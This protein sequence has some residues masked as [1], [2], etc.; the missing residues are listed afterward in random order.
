LLV[1]RT[2]TGAAM[3]DD[4][5]APTRKHSRVWRALVALVFALV[6][7]E[8]VAWAAARALVVRED[9]SH[10]DAIAVLA[11]SSAYVERT[12]FAAKLYAQGRA[13][14][15]LL[16]NDGE[17]G[18][19][20][21]AE[22]RNPFFI[23]RAIDELVSSG[24]PRERITVLPGLVSSTYDEARALRE[25]AAAHNARSL[26]VVTSAYHTR[27]ALWTLRR[28][29]KGDEIEIGVVPVETGEQT[30]AP[31]SW[32]LTRRGWQSVPVEYAKLAYYHFHY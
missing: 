27:R 13:P 2:Q 10:A 16:T 7:W 9:V 15:V 17:R 21:S 26:L 31:Y 4:S 20:S 1:A 22:Q 6:V 5:R 18:G 32:W 19:W 29:T 14:V 30:P 25:Y 23:E 12:R 8:L 24:V 11:G 28:V 3:R